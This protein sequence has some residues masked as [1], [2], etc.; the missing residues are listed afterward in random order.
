MTKHEIRVIS[1]S[2]HPAK[3]VRILQGDTFARVKDEE[4]ASGR[5]E[6]AKF[7]DEL[8]SLLK[9]VPQLMTTKQ[10]QI[11]LQTIFSRVVSFYSPVYIHVLTARGNS[12]DYEESQ[13]RKLQGK[14]DWRNRKKLHAMQ[15]RLDEL[16]DKQD[17]ML[18][19]HET[20]HKKQA[21]S[22]SSPRDS[23]ETLGLHSEFVDM[24]GEIVVE[25]LALHVSG[26]DHDS[27][28]HIKEGVKHQLETLAVHL[29]TET[30][31]VHF[32]DKH[33]EIYKDEVKTDGTTERKKQTKADL[34]TPA[35]RTASP[36]E[37]QPES[38]STP[39]QQYADG[40]FED[41]V[42]DDRPATG[43]G[44]VVLPPPTAAEEAQRAFAECAH[45]A[46]K[47]NQIELEEWADELTKLVQAGDSEGI[48]EIVDDIL[49]VRSE[50]P[51][52]ASVRSEA[53]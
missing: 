37:Q 1:L 36:T 51:E 11:W 49:A 18:N 8:E 2:V 19:K 16:H 32:K 52:L 48:H 38:P 26:A 14:K 30:P 42:G 5:L 29:H 21:G 39:Q 44:G 46:P 15:T 10:G 12:T 3:C 35:R 27:D 22:P 25:H 24:M 7:I 43:M 34:I 50:N 33:G 28:E 45:G 4:D 20:L 47:M 31:K 9:P 6:R 23:E 41:D 13:D 17:A 53:A 40:Q